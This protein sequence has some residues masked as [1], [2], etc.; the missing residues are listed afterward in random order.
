MESPLV[1][2]SAHRD[3]EA[4]VILPVRDES[5]TLSETLDA[6][7][8]QVDLSGRL[9]NRESFEV[10]LLLNNCTDNSAAVAWE[11]KRAHS[12]I[13]LHIAETE[14]EPDRAHAGTARRLLMD[15]AWRRL[16]R[17]TAGSGAILSTD[18]DTQVAPD[19]IA[20]N[21]QALTTGTDAVGG[22]IRLKRGHLDQ[23]PSGAR[24]AYLRD[25]K[26]QRL[27]AELEDLLDP[28]PHDPWPRHLH[29]FGASLGCTHEAYARSGGMPPVRHLE[30]VAFVEALERSGARLR[31]EPRAVVYTSAR[32]NGRAE[33]G[34][35]GQ[36]RQWQEIS[37]RGE[38][39]VVPSA[40]WLRHR[41]ETVRQMRVVCR[42]ARIPENMSY[43]REWRQRIAEAHARRTSES[44]FLNEVGCEQLAAETFRGVRH[45]DIC[46]VNGNLS[47]ALGRSKGSPRSTWLHSRD[48][49]SVGPLFS[50]ELRLLFPASRG[51][52]VHDGLHEDVSTP[53]GRSMHREPGRQ[54][55]DSLA[56]AE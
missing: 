21:L 51:G 16:A 47:W 25:R 5:S 13:S 6:L 46:K 2:G 56:P 52:S 8:G 55:G 1:E 50:A 38:R 24:L 18:S 36:L 28:Q 48:S 22:E 3:C 9:L 27:V 53:D 17:Q 54:S 41:L 12:G 34:L 45:E 10:L 33:V 11:W 29:H 31:H 43:T 49:E 26:Y 20:Q 32:M 42:L 23:L 30:D 4:A 40:A 35:S 19:W 37:E 15:T 39:H 7:A 44:G 14:I